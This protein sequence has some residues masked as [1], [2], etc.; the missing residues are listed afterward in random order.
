LLMVISVMVVSV[1]LGR[2]NTHGMSGQVCQGVRGQD[3]GRGGRVRAGGSMSEGVEG[4][5][6]TTRNGL[7]ALRCL[8]A[9]T[10]PLLAR[11]VWLD[12]ATPAQTGQPTRKASTK[13]HTPTQQ[14]PADLPPQN[15]HTAQVPQQSQPLTPE[16]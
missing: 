5:G 8:C 4:E 2:K 16:V 10:F 12:K 13:E 9:A 6:T 3:G 11:P 1:V 7:H 14:D 15:Q